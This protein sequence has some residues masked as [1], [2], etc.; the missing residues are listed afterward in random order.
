MGLDDDDLRDLEMAIM[1]GP[2]ATPVEPGTGGMRKLRFSPE[3]WHRGK[4]GG[5]RACYAYFPDHCIVLLLTAYDKTRRDQ[6][7]AKQKATIRGLIEEVGSYL[8][9]E[10]KR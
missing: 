2:A 3:R 9:K 6:L 7:T 5:G 1:A 10:H 4:R 8:N